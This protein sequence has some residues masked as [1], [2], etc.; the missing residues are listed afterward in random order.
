MWTHKL[1]AVVVATLLC[2]AWYMPEQIGGKLAAAEKAY[3][4][5]MNRP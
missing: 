5:E 4:E 1:L 3:L 2:I